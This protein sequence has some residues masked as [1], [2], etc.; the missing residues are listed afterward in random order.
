MYVFLINHDEP[1]HGIGSWQFPMVAPP[2]INIIPMLLV[3]Y[4]REA[5]LLSIMYCPCMLLYYSLSLVF[6]LP[7]AMCVL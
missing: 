1:R 2:W 5:V 3:C 7:M 4:E 6:T